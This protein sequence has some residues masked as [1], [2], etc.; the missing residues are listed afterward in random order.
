MPK[1]NSAQIEA[2]LDVVI[3]ILTKTN[4]LA[5]IA[6]VAVTGIAALFK[7]K[8]MAVPEF[9]QAELNAELRLAADDVV[10]HAEDLKARIR[11][12]FGLATPADPT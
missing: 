1:P 10:A 12:E 11:A 6:G 4:A 9:T 8:G 7:K 5:A 3:A 2:N